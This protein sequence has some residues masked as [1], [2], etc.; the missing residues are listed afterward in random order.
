[1]RLR[2][3]KLRKTP[4]LS[5]KIRSL[6][7]AARATCPASEAA[8]RE[9]YGRR[10][11]RPTGIRGNR[12]YLP[13]NSRPAFAARDRARRCNP[14]PSENHR[15]PASDPLFRS[16][17]RAY[18]PRV[19]GVILSGQL[20]AGFRGTDCNQDAPRHECRRRS[21][22]MRLPPRCRAAPSSTRVLTSLFR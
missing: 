18:G 8:M 5:R 16:A 1:M 9:Q 6:Q 11:I 10:D 20:G 22:G 13:G 2:G 17:A 7:P 19:A 4:S 21:Q 3:E 12:G 15:R 14:W